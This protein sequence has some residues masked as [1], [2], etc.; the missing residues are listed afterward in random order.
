[1]YLPDALLETPPG[2]GEF[3]AAYAAYIAQ[4]RPGDILETLVSQQEGTRDLLLAIPE[5][6]AG[7]R[8][9]AGKWSIREVVGHMADT[10]RVFAY[11]AMRIARGDR[12]PLPPFDENAYVAAAGFDARPLPYLAAEFAAVRH[13]TVA[14]FAA[15]DAAAWERR[16]I[17]SGAEVSVRALAWMIAGHEAHHVTLLRTRYR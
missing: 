10:E 6:D 1:M 4:V 5:E 7:M 12:T 15:L 2:E 16:G 8:Y 11:R 17:A 13:A 3:A 14:F 9:A